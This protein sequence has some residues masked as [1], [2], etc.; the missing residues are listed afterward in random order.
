VPDANAEPPELGFERGLALHQQGKLANAQRLYLDV[1]RRQPGHFDAWHLLGVIALQSG[2]PE[3]AIELIGKAIAL[4]ESVAAA[5]N[6]R[7]IALQQRGRIDAALAGFDQAI[8]LQPDYA[9]AYNNRGE[10]LRGLGRIEEALLGFDKAIALNP[11][12]AVAHNNRGVILRTA[13][14]FEEALSTY[15]KAIAL[16]PD[17]A[18]AWSNR[19]NALLDLGRAEAALASY[20]TAI[21]LAPDDAEL[22]K[23]RGNA[24]SDLE[25]PKEALASFDRAIALRPDYAEAHCDR[26]S[27]LRTL[28]RPQEALAAFDR[29]IALK[30]GDPG[31]YF[32]RG[33]LLRFEGRT[34]DAVASLEAG[35]AVD[36]LHGPSRLAACL[37]QLPVIYRSQAEIASRRRRYVTALERLA[38]AVTEPRVLRS[39]T[40]AIGSQPFYLPYQG[41]NDVVPQSI[42]GGLACRILAE[43]HK[44]VPLAQRP[45]AGGRIRLGIVSGFFSS[46]TVFKLFLE[47]WLTEIDR[48]RFEVI[49]FHT[50]RTTDAVTAH[51]AGLCDRFVQGLASKGA[52]REAIAD[53]VPHVL[54]YPEIGMDPTAG[55][56][57]G[58]RLSP[59]QCVAWGHPETTGMPTVDYF[60]S[61]DLME[62]PDAAGHYTERLVRLPRLGLHYTPHGIRTLALDRTA[63]DLDPEVPIFWS[64]QSLFKYPPQYDWLFPRIAEAVG[65]C[66]FV[67]VSTVTRGL[68]AVFRERLGRAFAARGLNAERYCTIMPA[69]P[70]ERY[71][72]VAGLA[73]VILDPPGWSGG[74]S[75]LDCLVL[76][77]AIVTLPGR[78]MRGCHTAAILRLIGCEATIAGSP[79]EYV[80]IAARLAHDEVWRTQVSQ[81]VAAGKHRAF[82]DRGYIRALETFLAE[83]VR[84]A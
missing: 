61:S 16:Q 82:R 43:T 28:E 7:A 25:R 9:E 8:M 5:H 31:A 37:A 79:D 81:A 73:D 29:A 36:P 27:A 53:A 71:V 6:N 20:D 38:D 68:T 55:W 77:P 47:S 17:Y 74:K 51:A 83:A 41:E 52:W 49:G 34:D 63:L 4:D 56:L 60:L 32:Y 58:Q 72:G 69:M 78:F 35:V 84:L 42:H 67:F 15:D 66:R 39:I 62:P 18:G 75:T 44:A 22:H 50:S 70:H 13:G 21:A 2:Q 48:D 57:A 1:L 40:E 45:P 80:V 46:H 65:E 33:E 11:D 30:P 76:N 3:T 10:L 59:V 19:G 23:R 26:G 54:L 24:L 12:Y 64:G 14:R